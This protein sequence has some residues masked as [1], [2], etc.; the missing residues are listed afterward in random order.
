MTTVQLYRNA[1]IFIITITAGL[2][3]SMAQINYKAA[4][5]AACKTDCSD[6]EIEN[7]MYQYGFTID[8]NEIIAPNMFV[9]IKALFVK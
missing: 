4:I 1:I 9:K 2:I 6:I 5:N 3:L 8:A 7:A